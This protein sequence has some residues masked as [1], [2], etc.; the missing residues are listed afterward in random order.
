MCKKVFIV[1]VTLSD[2]NKT[3]NRAATHPSHKM[4]ESWSVV[5]FGKSDMQVRPLRF[6]KLYTPTDSS[7]KIQLMFST[8][9]LCLFASKYDGSN[10]NYRPCPATNLIILIYHLQGQN[11]GRLLLLSKHLYKHDW[12]SVYTKRHFCINPMAILVSHQALPPHFTTKLH[13]C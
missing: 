1:F 2:L 12:E 3:S 13:P 6:S 7:D 5:F 9:L 4:H 10:L 8:I 11:K